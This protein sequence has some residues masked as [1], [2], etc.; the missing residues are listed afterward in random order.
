LTARCLPTAAGRLASKGNHLIAESTAEMIEIKPDCIV[1]EDMVCAVNY[2]FCTHA[3]YS[4]SREIWLKKDRCPRK[5][6]W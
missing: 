4:Y 6:I 1:L 5:T 3:I 2:P